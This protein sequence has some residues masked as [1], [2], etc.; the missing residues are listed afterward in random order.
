MDRIVNLITDRRNPLFLPINY[1]DSRIIERSIKNIEIGEE[2]IQLA[3]TFDIEPYTDYAGK[4]TIKCAKPF[5]KRVEK[6]LK[7]TKTTGTFFVQGDL[8]GEHKKELRKLEKNHEIG[9]HGYAHELWGRAWFLHGRMG[10]FKEREALIKKSLEEFRKNKIKRPVSFRAPY[11]VIDRS[12]LA[13]LEKY[14]FKVDSSA[15]S[16]KGI[17]PVIRHLDGIIEV[18]ASVNPIQKI[19]FRKVPYSE[20]RVFNM[21]NLKLMKK[22]ELLEYVRD[23]VKIQKLLKQKPFLV[24][25]AHPWEFHKNGKKTCSEGN[26]KILEDTIKTLKK[27]FKIKGKKISGIV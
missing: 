20:Y 8:V 1:L 5:F 6:I 17:K 11:M 12:S 2:T 3:L 10:T 23:I 25:F 13:L 22:S 16:Y 21:H 18:P 14:K 24:F 26:Y 15:P 27:E 7:K 9:L 4:K 19:K